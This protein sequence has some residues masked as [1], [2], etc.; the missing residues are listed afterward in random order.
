MDIEH[1]VEDIKL[2]C[3]FELEKCKTNIL[4]MN[5]ACDGPV[6]KRKFTRDDGCTKMT[7]DRD[8]M[9]D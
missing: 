8:V 7:K 2:L 9:V 5:G 4:S 1:T 6:E 3:E